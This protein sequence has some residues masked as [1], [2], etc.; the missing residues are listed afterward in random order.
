MSLL[1]LLVSKTYRNFTFFPIFPQIFRSINIILTG[2]L[3]FSAKLKN[4]THSSINNV[5]HIFLLTSG[6]FYPH[7]V[8]FLLSYPPQT[9]SIPWLTPISEFRI[10]NP[11]LQ[12]YFRIFEIQI[13]NSEIIH[14]Y[15]LALRNWLPKMFE[16]V[17]LRDEQHRIHSIY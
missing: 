16:N 17:K 3:C 12:N 1:S 7:I 11:C 13:E 6:T 2:T 5:A 14:V 15:M 8:L 10:R 9:Y 4:W